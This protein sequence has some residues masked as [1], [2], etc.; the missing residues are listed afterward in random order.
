M[1]CIAL[2]ITL[3]HL[4]ILSTLGFSE[5]ELTGCYLISLPLHCSFHCCCFPKITTACSRFSTIYLSV[6]IFVLKRENMCVCICV[7]HLIL[8]PIIE[9]MKGLITFSVLMQG[10][11]ENSLRRARLCSSG[12]YSRVFT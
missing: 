5:L 7:L 8:C 12:L 4:F 2:Q 11:F 1:F 6:K 9:H 10:K 3:Y